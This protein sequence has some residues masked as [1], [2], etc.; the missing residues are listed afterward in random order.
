MF[1]CFE[2]MQETG[3]H[4]PNDVYT[5]HLDEETS[6]EFTGGECVRTFV[7]KRFKECT[8]IAHTDNR[9]D[10]YFTLRQSIKEKRAVSPVTQGRK[11]TCVMAV[12]LEIR[13][14]E[15]LSFLPMKHS[16]LAKAIGFEGV[17][18]HFFNTAE[19]PKYVGPMPRV[20][21]FGVEYMMLELKKRISELVPSQSLERNR[22]PKSTAL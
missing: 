21:H 16:K 19:N 7:D 4:V 2:C 5:L 18:G 22:F 20:K 9:C 6:W 1:Y 15:S 8:F 3:V 17:K 11:L 14:I 13:F 10:G 12:D